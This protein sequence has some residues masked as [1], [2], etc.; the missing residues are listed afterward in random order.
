MIPSL[1]LKSDI[2]RALPTSFSFNMAADNI[3]TSSVMKVKQ[4]TPFFLINFCDSRTAKFITDMK[5]D[6]IL[7]YKPIAKHA[8]RMEEKLWWEHTVVQRRRA[9]LDHGTFQEWAEFDSK[10][11]AKVKAISGRYRW[12]AWR[13]IKGIRA[14]RAILK[15]HAHDRAEHE[16]IKDEGV[17]RIMS[18]VNSSSSW[19]RTKKHDDIDEDQI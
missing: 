4:R 9:L 8:W 17:R 15:M 16:R 10:H 14:K 18:I 19:R 11:V 12:L 1:L 3:K 5:N 13:S 2:F 6:D 7:M